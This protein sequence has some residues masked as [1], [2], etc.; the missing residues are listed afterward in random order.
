MG[1]EKHVSVVSLTHIHAIVNTHLKPTPHSQLYCSRSQTQLSA[2]PSFSNHIYDS[3]TKITRALLLL[4]VLLKC[5]PPPV[6]PLAHSRHV[7]DA[8]S[9]STHQHGTQK[10]KSISPICAHFKLN[11]NWPES[12]PVEACV[13]SAGPS[14]LIWI[15]TLG[16]LKFKL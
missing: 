13:V 7:Y 10:K 16:S 11:T 3:M 2:V 15:Q 12:P 14:Y 1:D 6:P 4:R 8:I 5:N 9:Q